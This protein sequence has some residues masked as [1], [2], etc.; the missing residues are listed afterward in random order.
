MQKIFSNLEKHHDKIAFIDNNFKKYNYSFIIDYAVKFKKCIKNKS[1]IL[2]IGSNQAASAIG[3]ISFLR[4]N[5]T[6]ILLD[7]SFSNQYIKKLIKIYKPEYIYGED[8]RLKQ[9]ELKIQKL[10]CL[11]FILF[12][13]KFKKNDKI[14]KKNLLLIS[15]SGSTNSPKFVRLSNINLIDNTKKIIN[16]LKI[17]SSHKTITTMPFG[18]SYGLSI[19]NSHIES[20]GIV[21][22]NKK[23]VFEKDFWKIVKKCKITSFGGVPSFYELLRKL[24]FDKT[25]SPNIKY[26]TQAGGKLSNDLICYYSKIKNLKFYQMYGQAEASPRIA[27]LDPKKNLEKIGS[28][29]KPLKGYRLII[30]KRSLS[31]QENLNGEFVLHGKNVCL[32]YAKKKEDLNKGD[33]NRGKI[34]TGDLGYRDSEGYYY[35][36]GRKKRIS[37]IFGV[38]INLEDIEFLL[39]KYNL[40]S[41][42]ITSNDY[43]S[44]EIKEN[45]DENKLKKIIHD[46]FGVKVNY[47]KLYKVE[48]FTH[49][50]M[51][52]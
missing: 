10:K 16:Y 47:I 3:Y 52:K 11:N 25:F 38:R 13:T 8:Q 14:N 1:L 23:S 49:I 19:I 45:F 9:I 44:I 26:L 2:M 22:F 7:E 41:K 24:K 31:T 43:L 6:L 37:K 28:I 40:S 17:N 36:T 42:C 12:K 15:T 50:N 5:Y 20:G 21:V 32:G 51:F 29:G 39:K 33:E 35:I 48:K 30:K 18:Y 27:Y 34:F 46:N 4:L